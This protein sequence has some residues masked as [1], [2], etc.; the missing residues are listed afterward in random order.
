[1]TDTSIKRYNLDPTG[2]NPN[3]L[4]IGETKVLSSLRYRAYAPAYG[5]FFN[6]A[7]LQI[8]DK[9]TGRLLIKEVDYIGT[10]ILED[11]SLKY[12]K[13]ICELILVK[14]QNVSSE[15]LA[16]YQLLGGLYQRQASN[17]ET[18]YEA[19]ISDTRAVDWINVLNKQREYPPAYHRHKLSQVY[20]FEPFVTGLERIR[21]AI[22]LSDVAAYE[23]L[24]NWVKGRGL[25]VEEF[26]A[27]INMDKFVTGELLAW[28]MKKL[29]LKLPSDK[30]IDIIA[31]IESCCPIATG[32]VSAT[33]LFYNDR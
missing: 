13:E 16:N 1:M 22:V 18:L 8:W 15:I 30:Q 23:E 29:G 11:A 21:N 25:T 6:D 7:T 10:Q 2:L 31:M 32:S 33:S 5:P 27:G 12:G 3:N 14:N 26:Q 20:G 28:I 24:I 19:L 9:A 17:L 4:V